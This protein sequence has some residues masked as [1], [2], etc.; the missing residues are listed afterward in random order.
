M[1][2]SKVLAF[3]LGL[4]AAAS[5]SAWSATRR[6]NLAEAILP[7]PLSEATL[8]GQ[9]VS[10][11]TS[12]VSVGAL[13]WDM[14]VTRNARVENWIDF[15]AGRNR[16]KTELWLER[17]GRYV[18]MMRAELR[19]RGMPEDL[20]YLAMIESG[21]SPNAYSVAKAAGLWQFIAETGQIYGLEVS[22]YIDERRDP[23]KA[24]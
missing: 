23:V 20:I 4:S 13:T 3:G 17:S 11:V 16:K 12:T 22:P 18:P 7:T 1:Q 8:A 21:F 9:L 6:V 10:G 5:L 15:L 24:T 14:P 2:Y 19:K